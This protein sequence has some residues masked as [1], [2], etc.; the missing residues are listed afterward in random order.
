MR[1]VVALLGWVLRAS[2]IVRA[3]LM[4]ARVCVGDA[5]GRARLCAFVA[6]C[7]LT[8][9]QKRF[10]YVRLRC[11]EAL[12]RWLLDFRDCCVQLSRVFDG[13]E[14]RPEWVVLRLVRVLTQLPLEVSL[15]CCARVVWLREVEALH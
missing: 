7:C 6:G 4:G 14:L 13:V 1:A 8:L 2:S 12:E 5:H 3:A 9:A 11:D 15:S 10:V